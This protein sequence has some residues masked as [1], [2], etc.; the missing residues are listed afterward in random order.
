MK[1]VGLTLLVFATCLPPT[2]PA[3]AGPLRPAFHEEV[4]RAWGD[5]AEHIR[6]LGAQV[7]RHLRGWPG[8]SAP[9]E[10]PLISFMLDH[11]EDLALTA[12]QVSRLE[13]LRAEF[14]RDAIRREA[15]IRI[16]EMDLAALLERDPL[17]LPKV[18]ATIRETTQLRAELRI[19]RL[20][21]IE[22]GKALLSAE[23][24]ARLEGLLGRAPR[25]AA[26]QTPRP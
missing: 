26:E 15:D 14:T 20:R 25:H 1:G 4:G 21:T 24:R 9:A 7:E 5:V 10:R 3:A 16:A 18:E 2:A 8:A 23:Q 13:A 19:S 17:D 12:D 6:S 11:K 22:Q